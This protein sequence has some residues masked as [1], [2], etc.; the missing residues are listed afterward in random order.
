MTATNIITA[1][2]EYSVEGT[3]YKPEGQ[4]LHNGGVVGVYQD[5]VLTKLLK[6]AKACNNAEISRDDTNRWKLIGTPTEGAI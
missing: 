6:A 3:G 2:N 4:I 1:E 5:K